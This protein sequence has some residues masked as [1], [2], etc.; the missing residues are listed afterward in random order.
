M[1]TVG[2]NETKALRGE[3][4]AAIDELDL[5]HALPHPPEQQ[6]LHTPPHDLQPAGLG[7]PVG[8]HFLRRHRTIIQHNPSTV[9]TQNG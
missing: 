3:G 4:D 1:I 9:V 6:A 8:G 7:V 2:K 5:E